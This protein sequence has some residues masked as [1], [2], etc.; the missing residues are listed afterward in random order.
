MNKDELKEILCRHKL[1]LRNEDGGG[2]ADLRGANLCDADLRGAN[3]CDADLCGANL[4]GANLYG[5]NLYG[6]NLHGTDLHGTDLCRAD[7]RGANLY[8]ANLHGTD[9]CGANLCGADLC[10]ANLCG[11]NLYGAN[12]CKADLRGA[13]LRGA[14]LGG[15][16]LCKAQLGDLRI[17]QIA[18]VGSTNRMTTF[19]ADEN[20]VW[21]GCFNGTFAE[22]RDKI[23]ETY[24]NEICDAQPV[25]FKYRKQ[26]EA[27]I[28]YFAELAAID[29]MPQ[30]KELLED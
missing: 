18:R 14:N 10:G 23:R 7:L 12:L 16:D 21:C 26:Y 8:G 3:L 28:V 25:K 4:C 9:L 2:Q 15:A 17:Y 13:D 30:Y 27:A 20:K 1:W 29:G 19:W 24:S 5:A 6:A 22:W 11:A